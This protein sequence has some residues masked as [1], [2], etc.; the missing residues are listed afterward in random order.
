MKRY[1]K[2]LLIFLIIIIVLILSTFENTTNQV[3]NQV[4]FNDEELE[5]MHKHPI[6]QIGLDIEYA[7]FEFYE[8]GEYK[9]MSLDILKWLE[10]YTGL[11]FNV[12]RYETFDEILRAVEAKEIDMTGGVIRTEEREVYM[13]FTDTFYANFDIVLVRD[14]SPFI[15]EKD[16]IHLRTGAIKG[17]SVTEYLKEKYP[18]IEL[19]EV[20]NI[21]EGLR[22]LSFGELD[23]FVTDYSQAMY[24]IY[25]YGYNNINAISDAKISIDGNLRFGLRKDYTVLVGILNKALQNIPPETRSEIQQQ[26]I[27]LEVKSFISRDTSIVLLSVLGILVLVIL[28]TLIINRLLKR[29]IQL[30]TDQLQRELAYSKQIEANL[31]HMNET[32]EDQVKRRTSELELL[33]EDLNKTRE[34]AIRAEKMGFLG[35]LVAGVAHEINSPLG[36]VLTGGTH[37]KNIIE[38]IQSEVASGHLRK[39]SLEA[40]L[41][42]LEEISNMIQ[43]NGI[44]L[45][46]LVQNF[47]QLSVNQ[48]YEKVEVFNLTVLIEQ[49]M[50]KFKAFTTDLVSLK[51]NSPPTLLVE[52]SPKAL[53]QVLEHLVQNA[54]QHCNVPLPSLEINI[55]VYEDHTGVTISVRDNGKG[56]DTEDV[57]RIFDPF[58]TTKRHIG[59][60]GLGMHLLYNLVKYQ[61]NGEIE[62]NPSLKSGFEVSIKGIKKV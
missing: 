34:N 18:E 57:N 43:D 50:L 47:K 7:P 58:F 38:N 22:M 20:P 12:V 14:D 31:Q 59:N 23:A 27:G 8:D 1:L 16:L 17:Y 28:G 13:A 3:K 33:I 52:S 11:K 54:I 15:T 46:K 6:V 24:Y 35:N 53:S 45:S 37:L 19:D 32:L 48:A 25:K 60:S 44:R 55:L 36:V 42:Q 5:W 56:I 26:W 40:Y 29:E 62:I 10:D 4:I 9:G 49:T 61:L 51:I 30:K 41:T 39:K 2:W 21:T